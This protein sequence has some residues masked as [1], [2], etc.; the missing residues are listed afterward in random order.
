MSPPPVIASWI[1]AGINAW[2]NG[3]NGRLREPKVPQ[4]TDGKENGFRK[5]RHVGK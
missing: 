1:R 4:V 3:M 2:G 5:G